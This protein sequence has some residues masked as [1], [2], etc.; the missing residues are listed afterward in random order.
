MEPVEA[1][2]HEFMEYAFEPFFKQLKQ[3]MKEEPANRKAW[4]PI[5]AT[6]L[7]L[8][9][10]GNLLMLRGPEEKKPEWDALSQQLRA[11]GQ[12]LYQSAKKRDFELTTKHYKQFVSNCNACHEKFADGKHI[13]KP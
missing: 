9:E 1:D 12:K 13:Q 8:A 7:I 5:K 10:N 11:E 2:M 6:S 4:V 3:A